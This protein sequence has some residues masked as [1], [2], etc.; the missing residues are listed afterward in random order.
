MQAMEVPI[1]KWTIISF[2]KLKF[3]KVP[4][5][6]GTIIKPPPMPNI[7]AKTPAN[8]PREANIKISSNI[9]KLFMKRIS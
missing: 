4:I 6:T 9:T 3:T 2:S 8:I 7:P 5:K 1:A